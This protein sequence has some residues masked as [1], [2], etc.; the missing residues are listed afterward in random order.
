MWNEGRRFTPDNRQATIRAL[1]REEVGRVVE[2]ARRGNAVA[3]QC[4]VDNYHK[5]LVG[6]ILLRIC[7]DLEDA[8]DIV[9]SIWEL[10]QK[11]IL[12][13]PQQGG[14]DP[15]R[16]GFLTYVIKRFAEHL[17]KRFNAGFRGRSCSTDDDSRAPIEPVDPGASARETL[18]A[19]EQLR[20]R[21]QAYVELFRV[22]FLCGGYAHQQLAFGLSKHVL[23]QGSDRTIEGK[24][25]QVDATYGA[26]AFESLIDTYWSEYRKRSQL[27]EEQL[28]ILYGHLDPLRTRLSC[29]VGE[30]FRQAGPTRDRLAHLHERQVK[31]TCF[32]QYYTECGLTVAFPDWCDKLERR[33]RHVLGIAPN[34]SPD[35]S[36]KTAEERLSDGP[37]VPS[38]CNRC[39]LRHLP[40]CAHN[41]N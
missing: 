3:W 30:M 23:G 25:A 9:G 2:E 29:L 10:L 1:T 16:S 5:R 15:A 39:K 24:H 7:G 18:M 11:E 38:G 14:Y 26:T 20:V 4:L 8:N 28:N 41:G 32:R 22:T 6:F 37:V 17:I 35:E 34:I 21:A 13:T 31:E 36:A 40:P 27:D 33:V 19:Q 12:K